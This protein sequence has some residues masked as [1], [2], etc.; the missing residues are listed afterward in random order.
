MTKSSLDIFKSNVFDGLKYV[1]EQGLG[2]ASK[3]HP[4]PVFVFGNQ[5]SGTSA[6]AMLLGYATGLRT[7]NDFRGA[8]EPYMSQFLAGD[9]PLE[10]FI[11][12]NRYA[13]SAPILK[14]PALTFAADRIATSF[15]KSPCIFIVR[16]PYQNIRSILNR[17]QIDGNLNDNPSR[18]SYPNATWSAIMTG[19][20]LGLKG[21]YIEIQ[22][23]RWCHAIAQYEAM[24]ERFSLVRY[25]DFL[26]NKE[27]VISSLAH[28]VGL[29]AKYS[30]AT[31]KDIAFQ[32]KGQRKVDLLQFFGERN[33]SLISE[34]C[35]PSLAR[36]GYTEPSG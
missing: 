19:R 32:Q 8:W 35:G 22:A 34:I 11:K 23:K 18:E 14:E 36:F 27:A 20:D 2:L 4:N 21:H 10:R 15:R 16:N 29:E 6:I 33:L 28:H 17:L 30:I 31:K 9:I 25:E 3:P 7:Q 1:R 13:F 26:V 24:P 5:K 12:R